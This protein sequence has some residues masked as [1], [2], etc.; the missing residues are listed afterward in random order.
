MNA[1]REKLSLTR[2]SKSG[3]AASN[4]LNPFVLVSAEVA[5]STPCPLCRVDFPAAVLDTL[6][7][8]GYRAARTGAAGASALAA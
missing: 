5:G 2:A 6:R 1:W 7:G 4:A 3:C 8:F